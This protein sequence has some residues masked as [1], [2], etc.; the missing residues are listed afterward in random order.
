LNVRFKKDYLWKRFIM[1][2][3]ISIVP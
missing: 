2:L 1:D 3:N